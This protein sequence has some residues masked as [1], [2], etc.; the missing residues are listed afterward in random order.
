M[1][2]HNEK[3]IVSCSSDSLFAVILDIESYPEFVLGWN[4]AHICSQEKD[5]LIVEQQLGIGPVYWAFT[6]S[7]F[8]RKPE[9]VIIRSHDGPFKKLEINWKL[10]DA[11]ENRCA[12]ELH[13]H[14]EFSALVPQKLTKNLLKLSARNVISL[15]EKRALSRVNRIFDPDSA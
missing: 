4:A 2:S 5:R 9:Q 8:Y 3:S 15:F 6:S 14:A 1:I 13:I 12:V 10:A 7:A 11:G